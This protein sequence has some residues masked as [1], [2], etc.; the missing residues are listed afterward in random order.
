MKRGWQQGFVGGAGS[1]SKCA[2][3]NLSTDQAQQHHL[4]SLK[5]A[6]V[7]VHT[8]ENQAAVTKH[9]WG[10]QQ[11]TQTSVLF[12][13][14]V[15]LFFS[16]WANVLCSQGWPWTWYAADDTFEIQYFCLYSPSDRITGVYSE[17][18]VW[19]GD[20]LTV[21]YI[22]F[23]LPHWLMAHAFLCVLQHTKSVWDACSHTL[24]P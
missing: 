4:G 1:S 15:S 17:P 21:L 5:W 10:N 23:N 9:T 18:S 3:G 8:C 12:F 11:L 6:T 20:F 2:G 13:L 19:W 7:T 16:F 14:Q 22:F 24:V